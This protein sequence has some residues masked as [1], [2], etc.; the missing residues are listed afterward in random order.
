MKIAIV[1]TAIPGHIA[2]DCC[3]GPSALAEYD[4]RIR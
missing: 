1:G 3:A 4:Q 2:V